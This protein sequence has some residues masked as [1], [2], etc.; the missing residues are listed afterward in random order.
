MKLYQNQ[1]GGVLI[2]RSAKNELSKNL[3]TSQG[4]NES[5]GK[6]KERK[7]CSAQ[8][9]GEM[10]VKDWHDESVERERNRRP[11]Q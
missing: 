5:E 9:E 1:L 11:G 8:V 3:K 4:R 2:Q 10:K 7:P 6:G